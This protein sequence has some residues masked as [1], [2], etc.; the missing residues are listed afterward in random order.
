MF[1]YL[2]GEDAVKRAVS[3]NVERDPVKVLVGGSSPSQ[4]SHARQAMVANQS[5][6]LKDIVRFNGCVLIPDWHSGDCTCLVNRH[7]PRFE[8]EIRI[9]KIRRR[10]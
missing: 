5:P 3:S 4:P 8:S 1:I 2:P 6:K 9:M 7:Y 10:A